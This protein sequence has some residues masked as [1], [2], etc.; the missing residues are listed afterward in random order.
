[1]F[2][3]GEFVE[4]NEKFSADNYDDTR[5]P[6]PGRKAAF[7]LIRKATKY[8]KSLTPPTMSEE[9]W[10]VILNESWHQLRLGMGEK[11]RRKRRSRSADPSE[12]SQTE[13][14]IVEEQEAD[15]IMV[16]DDE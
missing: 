12:M 7:T 6:V 11:R 14:E 1:M 3:T 2:S 4:A 9:K 10:N 13:E 16:S 15:I 8:L 5:E